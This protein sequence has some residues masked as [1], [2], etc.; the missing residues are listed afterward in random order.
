MGRDDRDHQLTSRESSG[1]PGRDRNV[2][3]DLAAVFVLTIL[4]SVSVLVPAFRDTPL[5][6]FLG[7]PFLLFLPGYAL[8]SVLF[9][10]RRT[11]ATDQAAGP[12]IN[13]PGSWSSKSGRSLG[14]D[15]AS[16]SRSISGIERT[17]LSFGASIAIVVLIGFSLNF[18]PWGIR[19]TPVILT[20]SGF[21]IVATATGVIRRRALPADERF[22][23]PYRQWTERI[24]SAVLEPETRT[25]AILNIVL[26][27]SVLLLASGV[28]Y[29]VSWEEREGTTAF[30]LLT[31]N[32]TGELVAT[33]YPTEFAPAEAQSLVVGIGNREGE[34]VNYT[35]VAELQRVETRN[36]TTLVTERER[37]LRFRTSIGANATWLRQHSVDPTMEGTRLRLTYLLY[38]GPAPANPTIENA[39]REAHLSVNVTDRS[40][41]NSTELQAL[42]R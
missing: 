19:L 17:V 30:Y 8:V 11:P 29:T 35:V 21:T 10:K 15:G 24:G 25:D 34:R 28:I 40:T 36:D 14:T 33:D 37:L 38:R 16:S 6:T 41:G 42:R 9:P 7:F 3:V 22:A 39:Y 20:V 1:S 31:E 12:R 13:W 5:R 26:I 32:E 4:T 27:C 2:P 18:T 23:V